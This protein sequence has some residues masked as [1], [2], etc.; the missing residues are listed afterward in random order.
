MK[1]SYNWLKNYINTDLEPE[2]MS[3]LLTDCGLEVEGLEKVE[4]VKGGLNGIVI[5]KVLTC[6]KHPDADKLSVTTVDVGQGE[7]LN[8]VC[9][10]PNVAAGQTVPVATIGAVMYSGD[11]SFTIKKTK[12][13]G[14]PSEGMICA[15]D[16][17][18][19][20]K[21]HDGILVLDDDIAIGTPAKEYFDIKEDHIFEIGLT[22]NRS[23]AT[24]HIGCARDVKAV[25]NRYAFEQENGTEAELIIPDV[26]AFKAEN[27]S[28]PIE[29]EINDEN[30]CRR[31]VGVTV[32]NVEVKESPEW[33]Q[34]Y[35]N[36]VGIRPIN[37]LVDISNFVMMETG[38]PLHFFDA[39]KIKGDKVIVRMAEEKEKFTT[40][41][42]IDR[43]LSAK[44]LMIC[45]AE[46]PMCIAG[47]F[48]GMNSGVTEETKSI[49]IESAWFDPPTIRKTSKRHTLQT[50]ASFRFERGSDIEMTTYALKRAALLI[51]ELAGGEI[52][53]EINDVYPLPLARNTVSIQYD[54]VF[55]LIGKTFSKELVKTILESLDIHVLEEAEDGLNLEIP[56]AK[57]EVTR[58]A[59]IVEEVLRV[60]GYNNVE[61]S[62]DVHSS[63]SYEE[64]PNPEKVKNRIADMLAAN[65][66]NEIMN[67]S[68][69]ASAYYDS[70]ESIDPET[71]VKMLNPLSKELNILRRTLLFS[72]LEVITYN[73][74]RKTTDLKLYEYG[75]SYHLNKNVEREENVRKRYTENNHFSIFL[76]GNMTGESWYQEAKKASFFDLKNQLFTVLHKVGIDT[77]NLKEVPT[78]QPWFAEGID[79]KIKKRRIASFGK[80]SKKYQKQFDIQ[81]PVFFADID[82]DLLMTS[83]PAKDMT[84]K[85]VSKFPEV[86]RDLALLVD[87]SVSFRDIVNVVKQNGGALIK[88]VNLFDVYEGDKLEAG[89]KSYAI[90]LILQ[91]P[92]KTLTD[93]IIDK[94]VNKLVGAFE[95]KIGASIR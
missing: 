44:D 32:S 27:N 79:L 37:N 20:G 89:K 18:G 65:G 6:E 24:G 29:I 46:N 75:K 58:E 60:Y 87:K 12:L 76:S 26:S 2:K 16:E 48:G 51:K 59:D 22:P 25:L 82:W 31:Y 55:S 14:V 68:L 67:N 61:I 72:G 95:N 34:N 19:L 77:T 57:V 38:Q 54:R 4:S 40:L 30:A 28:R 5:G 43:E 85:A 64:K 8:I 90:S 47:V 9:G 15:E 7:P 39:D 83:I 78:E 1:I 41:D 56:T 21:S 92:E 91:D 74:N 17:L 53:S 94:T 33:M 52:S 13:R 42:E 10:A 36:A 50:D 11:E 88:S 49:F 80:V 93:K 81:N 70:E 23:D 63:L 62:S 3:E 86:R 45:D 71:H 84:M 35:L 73:Q 66:Y 69:T